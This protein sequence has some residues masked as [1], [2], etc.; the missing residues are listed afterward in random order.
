MTK[1][2]DQREAQIAKHVRG[3]LRLIGDN[4]RRPGLLDTP[5]RVARMYKEVFVGLDTPPP[6]LTLF[7]RGENDEMVVTESIDFTSFCEHHLVPFVGVAHIGYVPG[8]KILGLSK[9]GRVVDYFAARPQIQE[10]M[11]AQIADYLFEKLE[12]DGIIVLCQAKHQCMS[13]RGIKKANHRTTT[14]AIRGSI[15]KSEFFNIL[16]LR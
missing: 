13:I 10:Q 16:K 12:P 1:S 6:K 9:F 2:I 15:D 3:I 14:S 4:P 8:K 5:D 11:T 7:D